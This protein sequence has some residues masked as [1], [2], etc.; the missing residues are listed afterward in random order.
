MCSHVDAGLEPLNAPK[1]GAQWLPEGILEGFLH[2]FCLY[3]GTATAIE[4]PKRSQ[5]PQ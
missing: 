4:T 1:R 5:Q 3:R 2:A